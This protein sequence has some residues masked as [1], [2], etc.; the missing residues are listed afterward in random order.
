MGSFL[1]K[2]LGL[3]RSWYIYYSNPFNQKKLQKFYEPFVKPGDLCFDIGSHLGN[4]VRTWNKMGAKVVALEPQPQCMAFLKRKFSN[5]ANVTLVE[6]AVGAEKG[7]LPLHISELTPTVST[8]SKEWFEPIRE[9]TSY[10][11][12]WNETI[13]VEVVTLD[14]LIETYGMPVFCKIDVENYEKEVLEGL[15]KPIPALSFE[16][17]TLTLDKAVECIELIEQLGNY[18]FNWQVGPSENLAASEWLSAAAMKTNMAN[19]E[20]KER[21]GDVLARVVKV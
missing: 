16:Y 14:D 11:V 9:S 15:S 4:R 7:E 1:R 10:E 20:G 18:E 2:K 12:N 3:I 8:L 6:K 21:H 5:K 19:P 13:M 17:F